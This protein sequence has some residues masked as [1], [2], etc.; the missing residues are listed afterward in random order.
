MIEIDLGM[1]MVIGLVVFVVCLMAKGAVRGIAI[2][3]FLVILYGIS[4][5]LP[6][7]QG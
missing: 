3:A 1:L 5:M 6:G 7:A 4:T 2:V